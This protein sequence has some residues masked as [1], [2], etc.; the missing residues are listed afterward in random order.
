MSASPR[1]PYCLDDLLP[2]QESVRC[3]RCRTPHHAACFAE[4]GACVS[5]GCLGKVDV[6][7]GMSLF[8][9]QAIT[10]QHQCLEAAA[11]GPFELGWRR[12]AF[13]PETR[14]PS[15]CPPA[16]AR[17]SLEGRELREGGALRGRAVLYAPLRMRWKRIDLLLSQGI[18][19]PQA[20]TRLTLATAKEGGTDLEVGSHPFH[21]ELR[22]PPTTGPVDPYVL[23]LVVVQGLLS[24]LRSPPLPVFLLEAPPPPLE[25]QAHA[26]RILPRP[27]APAA[28]LHGVHDARP[29]EEPTLDAQGWRP[30]PVDGARAGDPARSAVAGRFVPGVSGAGELDVRL[31]QMMTGTEV[32]IV[33]S[34]A[35]PLAS[36]S[37]ALRWELVRPGG[38]DVAAG[39]LPAIEE[40]RVLG[41]SALEAGRFG[42]EAVELVVRMGE[43]RLGALA[44]AREA[45]AH[46]AALRLRVGVDAYEP[47]G[48]V[49]HGP[50][51]AATYA[52]R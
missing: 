52:G 21:L 39:G 46:N 1:C 9:V 32:S 22:A 14:P 5:Y 13:L 11:F 45:G 24:E 29:V 38:A 48:R 31:P 49:R 6:K 4:N 2:D 23:E 15:R 27:A 44:A 26:I 19:R 41:P 43:G 7:A 37:V 51:R 3:A 18:A 8:N 17:L 28:G 47:S 35:G 34:G 40:V 20:V 12:L 30:L 50:T 36:L 33:L 10:I 16:Y 42:R 25:Q